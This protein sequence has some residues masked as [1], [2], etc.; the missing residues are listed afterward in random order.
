M[1][2]NGTPEGAARDAL[3]RLL[4]DGID[5]L[6]RYVYSRVGCDPVVAEDVLQQT[7]CAAL[8]NPRTPPAGEQ[9]EWWVRGIAKNMV[10][11]HW[12]SV[13]RDS[14]LG[15]IGMARR[16]LLDDGPPSDGE[17]IK[18]EVM[19]QLLLAV[20][21]LGADDQWL[22]YAFYRHGWSRAEIAEELG[23]SVKGVE[24]RLY[25]LRGR[26]RERLDQTEVEGVES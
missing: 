11:R 10:R 17:P 5:A 18:K 22:L 7:V 13:Q 4:S 1:Q 15:R 23:T 26:L 2:G 19:E 8:E 9:Q 24:S 12:R 3:R 16:W 14:G 21:D 20:S 25:R 6:Y